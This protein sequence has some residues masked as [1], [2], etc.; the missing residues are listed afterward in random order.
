[1]LI[2]G[3]EGE[4]FFGSVASLESRFDTILGRIDPETQIVILR[5]KRVRHPDAS[6]M[7]LFAAF[8][9][10]LEA[11]G[12]HVILCGVR[13]GFHDVLVR[14]GLAEKLG[15]ARIFREQPV[16]QTSTM[17]AIE[18]ATRMLKPGCPHCPKPRTPDVA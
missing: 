5:A 10:Q 11:R 17:L 6:G 3:L 18:H 7:A 15:E 1:V 16:R 14:S 2:Y 8:L 12:V 9:E 13:D 4:M